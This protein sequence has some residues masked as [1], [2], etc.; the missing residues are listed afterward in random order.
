MTLSEIKKV[1]LCSIISHFGGEIDEK[2]INFASQKVKFN[3]EWLIVKINEKTG[4]WTYFDCRNPQNN[5]TIIDFIKKNIADLNI[6]QI[7]RLISEIMGE[8]YIELPI[9]STF[10]IKNN[11]ENEIRHDNTN[12][13]VASK[14]SV[15]KCLAT[16]DIE[17]LSGWRGLNLSTI[18][19]FESEIKT[20]FI[21]PSPLSPVIKNFCFPHRKFSIENGN[22][23]RE[24]CG[25]EVRNTDFKGFQ[26]EKGLWGKG[27]D[28]GKSVDCYI[29]ESVFDAMSFHQIYGENGFYISLGGGFGVKQIDYLCLILERQQSQNLVCCFDSDEAGNKMSD[30][31][32]MALQER[33][34]HLNFSRNVPKN[35]KDFNELLQK[36]SQNLSI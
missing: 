1:N 6:P 20:E 4:D 30:T 19:E 12:P 25:Y 11:L 5:G 8:N 10:K 36:S 32:K 28:V 18:A 21:K 2:T 26:G 31:L 7:C 35:A 24:I 16:A 17:R 3:N 33:L 34:P 9:K 23:Q 15:K 27:V 22:L 14:M 13:V 29:F